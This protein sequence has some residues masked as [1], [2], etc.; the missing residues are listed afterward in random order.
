M[1]PFAGGVQTLVPS[2]EGP[3]V[4]EPP[5]IYWG[6]AGQ[7][8]KRF[9]YPDELTARWGEGIAKGGKATPTRPFMEAV[10][11]A[12]ARLWVFDLHFDDVGVD[13]LS[14]SLQHSRVRDVKLLTREQ[15]EK[16]L[17]T[18]LAARQLAGFPAGRERL[19]WIP[20]LRRGEFPF[21]HDRFAV[22]DEAVWHFGHTVGGASPLMVAASG[23]W[24]AEQ[25]A[26]GTF[27]RRIWDALAPPEQRFERPR[28]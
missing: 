17:D 21:A 14:D 7:T 8:L 11:G 16:W 24:N 5:C 9:P 22:V 27:Y 25:T 4:V 1:V 15:E 26:A 19:I 12:R 2:S 3:A 18:L 6:G 20:G 10:A 23:G 13:P 28:R